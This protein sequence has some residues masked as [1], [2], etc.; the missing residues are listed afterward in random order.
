MQG[1]TVQEHLTQARTT[2]QCM[3][4]VQRTI[5]NESKTN[6]TKTNSPS[7]TQTINGL[8]EYV[9][10]VENTSNEYIV[11]KALQTAPHTQTATA[12]R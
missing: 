11:A 1:Q 6:E 10:Y 4:N 8:K 2:L 7:W 12:N 9:Q 5:Q 3:E